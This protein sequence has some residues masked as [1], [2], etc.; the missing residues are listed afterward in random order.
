MAE[1]DAFL[2]RRDKEGNVVPYE[3]QVL[4]IRDKPLTIK[5][6]PTTVGS[7]KGMADPNGDAVQWPIDDKLRYV[8]EHVVEPDFGALSIEELADQMTVW[9][10]DMILIT[11]VQHGGPMRQRKEVLKKLPLGRPAGQS[12][13]RLRRSKLTSTN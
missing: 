2:V 11:A 5:I 7:L 9:D 1:I 13:K 12:K 3:V 6:L 10:L 8:R 4:G